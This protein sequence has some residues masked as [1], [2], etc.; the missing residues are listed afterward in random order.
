MEIM[1]FNFLAIS[2]KLAHPDKLSLKEWIISSC[3]IVV[4]FYLISNNEVEEIFLTPK[5]NQSQP[6]PLILSE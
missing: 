2:V 5:E 3:K 6:R 4:G 1:N